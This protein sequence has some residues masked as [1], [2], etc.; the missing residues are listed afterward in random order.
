M[1]FLHLH[2]LKATLALCVICGC[3]GNT[4]T[5]N[6]AETEPSGKVLPIIELIGSSLVD[7][8]GNPVSGIELT[9]KQYLLL[10][11]SAHWC[12]PCRVFTPKLV[13]FYNQNKNADN[14]EIILISADRTPEAMGQYMSET[15]MPW[16]ALSYDSPAKQELGDELGVEGIPCLVMFNNKG[17]VISSSYKNEK[18][19]GPDKVLNDLKD[20]LKKKI[21]AVNNQPSA[22]TTKSDT[23]PE[24]QISETPPK[25]TQEQNK[26]ED[27][28]LLYEFNG[29]LKTKEGY[30]AIINGRLVG[31]GDALDND[32]KV[33]E[34]NDKY[35][36]ISIDKKTYKLRPSSH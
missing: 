29:V 22:P 4:T 35:V 23:V 14:F 31:T 17:A 10:Y 32:A 9:R 19:V 1:R 30:T 12:P 18:Y 5:T 26:E 25:P 8:E 28:S 27:I 16:P 21:S 3:S 33:V 24:K 13:N 11:F 34:I 2:V 36:V 20:L 6:T 7:A 15:A